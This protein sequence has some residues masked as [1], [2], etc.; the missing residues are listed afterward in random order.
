MGNPGSGAG[1]K[2]LDQAGFAGA[3]NGRAAMNYLAHLYLS[4]DDAESLVGSLMGDFVKGRIDDELP[5]RVRSGVWLHRRVDSFTDAHPVVQRSKARIAPEFRRYA[6]ILIDM[7]YDH[8]L[9]R[10]WPDYAA[11]PLEHFSRRVYGILADR[12]H[13]FP[14]HMQRSMAYMVNNDLLM[15]YLEVTG[16]EHALIGI[17]G[18]LKRPSGLGKAAGELHAN[19]AELLHDFTEFFPELIAFTREAEPAVA[20]AV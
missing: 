11:Q 8:F 4:D 16:I 10:H 9:A 19:Y 5:E 13:T 3:A 6:G 2:D 15:S 14:S 20:N 12:Q 17:E 7:F 1:R 18:R